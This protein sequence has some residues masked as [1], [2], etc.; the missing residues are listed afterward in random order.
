MGAE[1]LLELDE[2]DVVV[3]VVGVVADVDDDLVRLDDAL[4]GVLH[5]GVV[6]PHRHPQLLDLDVH[7]TVRRRDDVDV[8]DG[9]AAAEVE[10]SEINKKLLT[11][12]ALA[13]MEYAVGVSKF[14]K[15]PIIL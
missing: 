2:G 8:R 4:V 11:V 15:N 12:F 10:I 7:H 1:G 14:G 9:R 6:V 3:E 5:P 13:V